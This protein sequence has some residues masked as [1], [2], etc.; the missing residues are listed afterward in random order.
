MHVVA[1]IILTDDDTV[2]IM[3][4]VTELGVG[5]FFLYATQLNHH[6]TNRYDVPNHSCYLIS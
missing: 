3:R 4:I 1:M 5:A 6:P 2:T